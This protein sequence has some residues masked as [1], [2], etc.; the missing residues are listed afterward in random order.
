MLEKMSPRALL[1]L[2]IVA[3]CIVSGLERGA[4]ELETDFYEDS[5]PNALAIVRR[6]MEQARQSDARIGAKLIRLHFHDC[7]VQVRALLSPL[8]SAYWAKSTYRADHALQ[9]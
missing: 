5:C 7:F 9:T 1:V 3:F 4:A 6:V 8:V 2:A